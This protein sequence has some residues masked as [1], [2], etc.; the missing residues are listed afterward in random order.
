MDEIFDLVIIGGGPAGTH[1]ASEAVKAGMKTALIEADALGGTCLNRGCIPTKTLLHTASLYRE[2]KSGAEIGLLATDVSVDMAALQRYKDGVVEKLVGS[3]EQGLQKAKVM[4]FRGS[5]RLRSPTEVE[6]GGETLETKRVLLATGSLPVR[7]PVPGIDLPGVYDSTGMLALETIP[8]SVVI[9]GGGVVGM[10]FA[11]LYCDLGSRVTVIE[12]LDRLLAN[13]DRE[14]GQSLR[15][16]LKKRGADIHTSASLKEIRKADDGL[17]CVYTEKETEA[18]AQGDAVLIAVGRRPNTAELF[19]P[20]CAPEM[21]RGRIVVNERYETSLPGVW[22]VGDVTGGI[23]LA[24]MASAEASN[25]VAIMCGKQPQIRTDVVPSCVYTSPEIASVGISP[26]DAKKQGLRVTTKK[27][28]MTANGKTVLSRGERGYISVTADAETGRIL[29]AQM[30]C[31]RATDMIGEF[32]SAIVNGLTLE[33]LAP[34][35]RPHPTYN[36][37]IGELLRS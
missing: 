5:A 11:S 13:M 9:I 8:E 36:E 27:V 22:A 2:M 30:L 12:A 29:G 16:S 7:I 32:A 28:P 1:A 3:I 24:H 23:Q 37:A 17:V 4:L 26:Q 21:E 15:M 34:V 10:E 6:I 25:A 14:L 31:E 19:A 18:E 20:G 35:I 33:Q